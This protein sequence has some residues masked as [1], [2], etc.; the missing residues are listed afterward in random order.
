MIKEAPDA[1]ELP[2]IRPPEG[3]VRPG[4]QVLHD[5]HSF[6]RMQLQVEDLVEQHASETTECHAVWAG[7]VHGG[8]RHDLVESQAEVQEQRMEP[9]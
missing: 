9:C 5:R 3:K 6:H 2:E 1:G 8:H 7:G 4:E